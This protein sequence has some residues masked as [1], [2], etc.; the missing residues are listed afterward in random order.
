MSQ[1]PQYTVP[2]ELIHLGVGQPSNE[3]LP[4]DFIR[5]ATAHRMSF[6]DPLVLQ[7]GDIPGYK[8]LREDLSK[9]LATAPGYEEKIDISN[10]FITNGNTGALIL[11]CTFFTKAGDVVYAEDP[12]YFL[13]LSTFKD[14]HLNVDTVPTDHHGLDVDALEIKLKNA[15]V[16]LRPK[17]IYVIPVYNN[18][19]GATLTNERREK[20]VRLSEEYNFLI[21][22]D[23][24]Y[25][26][27]GFEGEPS[28]PKYMY[29]FDRKG[30]VLSLGSFSKIL[31]PSLRLGWIVAARPILTVF[32]AS[33]QFDSSGGINPFI[34]SIVHS[35][36]ELGLLAK[37]IQR[38]K[39]AL[40]NGAKAL[41][42]ALKENLPPICKW[43]DPKGGYFLWLELPENYDAEELWPIA[44]N[45]HKVQFHPGIK[46][47]ATRG[48]R[49]CL[50]LSISYYGEEKL[51]EGAV[52]LGKAIREYQQI[53]ESRPPKAI[54]TTQ[55]RAVRVAVHGA[56]GRLGSLIVN[57]LSSGQEGV[58]FAG[59]IGRDRVIPDC[60]VVIDVSSAE[61]LKTLLSTLTT[62]KVVIG[63]TGNLPFDEINLYAK[64]STVVIAPNFSVGVPLLLDLLKE[65]KQRVPADWSIEI[66]EAHHTAKKDA[67]SGTAKRLAEPLGGVDSIPIHSLRIGDTIG[68]HTVWLA[69]QGERLELKHVATKREVFAIGAV[70]TSKWAFTQPIGIFH[71]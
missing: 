23:E 63:T 51:R 20:L 71:I 31:A 59:A 56:S 58:V 18:P 30:T 47:S 60:D 3:M 11:A 4:L 9:F 22:A 39:H 17:F 24:V 57:Q 45:N 5:E 46:F 8:K 6:D 32:E 21:L 52:R 50:R 15:P 49:N 41:I 10:L 14:F 44:K 48:K 1:Y 43:V 66:T 36:L 61:G 38:A 69:G 62:Q 12:S 55:P 42:S 7:Y 26:L 29:S 19:M 54:A 53:V 28:P 68:E 67:P 65:A 35:T 2:A 34:S 64:K 37:N 27:L 16:H 25:Q 70:R 40:T 13:A 33:G